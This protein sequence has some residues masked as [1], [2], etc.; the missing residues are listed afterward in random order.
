M[1]DSPNIYIFH[2]NDDTAMRDAVA[3]MQSKLGDA[4]AAAMNTSHLEGASL[5]LDALRNAAMASPFLASHRLVVASG[6][7]KVFSAEGVRKLFFDFL[8]QI[9]STTK[10]VLLENPS[11]VVKKKPKHW[12]LK[13]AE[14]E[15]DRIF[16]R[17]CDL[18]EGW[19]MET[20]LLKKSEELGAKMMPDAAH[21]LEHLVGNN[22]EAAI[23]EIKK[24]MAYTG[25]SGTIQKTHVEKV[26]T[27]I[28]D[29][30][31]FFK[32]VDS[33]TSGN[34]ARTMELLRD[35]LQEQDHILLFFSLVGQFRLLLETKELLET[36]RGDVDFAKELGIHP[37]R[38]E[39]LAAQ[40]RRFTMPTLETI[41]QRLVDL[42]LQI[43]TG[44]MEPD[45]AME[46]FIAQL[47][48]QAV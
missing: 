8:Q 43:K 31:D 47:T 22:K 14:S 32:L 27:Q 21:E 5:T 30:G 39:K 45:L 6:A 20:W 4:N 15:G 35:L 19:Q 16:V 28:G 3:E 23:L 41:Y 10:L 7:S 11:L 33:M 1:A 37:Y 18:P 12:L 26:G 24:L 34:T 36:G 29:Q 42:D 17:A 40:A 25:Y 48:A 44:E 2:G 46:T 38:A 9:P 13:W